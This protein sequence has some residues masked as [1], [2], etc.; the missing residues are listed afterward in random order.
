M[1]YGFRN[2]RPRYNL[3]KPVEVDKVY[4]AEI[5]DVSRRGD[6]IAK[7]EGFIIFVPET[8]KGDHVKFKVTK[9]GNRFATG[10]LVET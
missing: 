2:S 5:E 7:I 6:G 8:K 1:S 9:V 4:E 3:K 10:E